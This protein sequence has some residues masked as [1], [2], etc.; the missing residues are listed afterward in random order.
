M[1]SSSAPGEKLLYLTDEHWV[2]YVPVT[3][4]YLALTSISLLLFAALLLF[5]F[6]HHW[7][8]VMLLSEAS[9][10]II[11][12]NHRV[13]RLHDVLFIREEM[14]EFAFEKMKTVEARKRGLLQNIFR[15]GSLKF[16]SGAQITQVP[17]PNRVARAVEQAMGLH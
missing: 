13:I 4:V 8:F 2:K 6:T 9:S 16:E 14:H 3:L 15:Y 17:H 5:L 11:V 10:C 12:T 1:P 7:F